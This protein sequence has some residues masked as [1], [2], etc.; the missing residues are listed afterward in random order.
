MK[1]EKICVSRIGCLFLVCAIL[2]FFLPAERVLA[3]NNLIFELDLS[4]YD[5]TAA[6]TDK[7]IRDKATDSVTERITVTGAP[8]LGE[9]E[10]TGEKYLTFSPANANG[11]KVE[12][13]TDLQAS[14][15]LT[16]ELWARAR[17][18][19]DIQH[20]LLITGKGGDTKHFMQFLSL[21]INTTDTHYA[22]RLQGAGGDVRSSGV[23]HVPKD[24][25]AHHV[26]TRTLEN[27]HYVMR[28]YIN[29]VLQEEMTDN[30]TT[31]YPNVLHIGGGAYSSSVAYSGDVGAVRVYNASMSVADIQA[32]YAEQ[33]G[34][35]LP[36][37]L[38]FVSAYP[39]GGT[40]LDPESGSIAITFDK[41]INENTISGI[42]LLNSEG[43]P[44]T[45]SL[46][47]SAD[48][49]AVTLDYSGLTGLSNYTL[50]LPDTLQ[51]ADGGFFVEKRIAYTTSKELP[52]VEGDLLF[53]L[54]ISAY[55]ATSQE[56]TKGIA[57]SVSNNA[58]EQLTVSGSPV[59]NTIAGSETSYLTLDADSGVMLLDP[60][61]NRSANLSIELWA[62]NNSEAAGANILLHK[63][64]ATSALSITTD[65]NN[66]LSYSPGDGGAYQAATHAAWSKWTHYVFTKSYTASGLVW[67]TYVNGELT[68]EG[69]AEA[70]VIPNLTDYQM[71]IGGHRGEISGF[72]GDISVLRIYRKALTQTEIQESFD[73][74]SQIYVD[75]SI[76]FVS[77]NPAE[78]SISPGQGSISISFDNYVD[79]DSIDAITFTK[80][81]GT[82]VVGAV[83]KELSAE[84]SKTVKISF[85]KLDANSSYS[86]NVP[87]SLQSIYGV[88]LENAFTLNFQ[89][90]DEENRYFLNVDFNDGSYTTGQQPHDNDLVYISSGAANDKTNFLIHEEEATGKQYMVMTVSQK[91]SSLSSQLLY[92]FAEPIAGESVAFDI[93]LRP[94]KLNSTGKGTAVREFFRV[95]NSI[96]DYKYLGQL[97]NGVLAGNGHAKDD[98]GEM[99]TGV[100][101]EDGYYH[102]TIVVEKGLDG[103]YYFEVHSDPNSP[104]SYKNLYLTS[105]N[106]SDITKIMFSHIYPTKAD[107]YDSDGVA[108]SY[109]RGYHYER[110]KLF[111]TNGAELLANSSE[112]KLYF[113]KDMDAESVL[114]ATY[115]LSDGE[116]VYTPV[117]SAYNATERSV[118]LELTDYLTPGA[119]YTVS[120]QDAVDMTGAIVAPTATVTLAAPKRPVYVKDV[121]LQDSEG[122]R[123]D[124]LGDLQT[125]E[126]GRISVS[127]QNMK[128]T[129]RNCML[130]AQHFSSTGKLLTVASQQVTLADDGEKT[131]QL[132]A[133]DF[134]EGDY[135]KVSVWDMTDRFP[136]ACMQSACRI[137]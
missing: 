115:S 51:S 83:K 18:A 122:N 21:K 77:S 79:A 101:A 59:K 56:A 16:I 65:E 60:L 117:P 114:S 5:S 6:E 111:G 110:P 87:E 96:E 126:V 71:Y 37:V 98:K 86:L 62:R 132:F 94:I 128:K 39:S 9:I 74:E 19:G 118:L 41:A 1:N 22:Y 52:V 107:Q 127:L 116:A 84:R 49:T 97:N 113:D 45:V 105:G 106:F 136:V 35:Y 33:K 4:A 102:L 3:S 119:V 63:K 50:L 120:A 124:F 76:S 130:F 92:K 95:Y 61:I 25:W 112:I 64:D 38:R 129:E 75:K 34:A 17:N 14:G 42:S 27:G 20:L 32:N 125:G 57:N 46:T 108:F 23:T 90:G 15:E 7:G 69:T 11:I 2:A 8:A 88:A 44:E 137:N 93:A 72:N 30:S 73:A 91:E 12:G 29:G 13:D 47:P 80:Q 66:A 26:I 100:L 67:N 53:D 43:R 133:A 104:R 81:D 131:L 134:A 135:L 55:D 68:N 54:D 89:T 123:L 31:R 40:V 10:E 48:G 103:Q 99:L 28:S 24:T 36:N 78:G 85:G 58:T 82:A 121:V 70:V 109:I